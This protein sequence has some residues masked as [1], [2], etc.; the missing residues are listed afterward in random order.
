MIA[1]VCGWNWFLCA[2]SHN[3]WRLCELFLFSFDC[4]FG[5]VFALLPI[6]ISSVI[7]VPPTDAGIP[8]DRVHLGTDGASVFTGRHN[9]VNVK[10]LKK[11]RFGKAI[12]CANHREAL[13]LAKVLSVCV[14]FCLSDLITRVCL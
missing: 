5:I 10:F 1:R 6:R 7:V 9:G 12:H 11:S 8:E 14:R 13:C 2:C 3:H 4:D